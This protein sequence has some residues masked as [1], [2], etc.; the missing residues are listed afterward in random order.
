MNTYNLG[1]TATFINGRAFKPNEWG[2]EGFPII[3]IQN[4]NDDQKI[5]N[6]YNGSCDPKYRVKNGDI[7]ISWSGS[8]GVYEWKGNDAYLN[9]HIYK[10]VFDKKEINK[11]YFKYV[12]GNL[13]TKVESY[14]HGSTMKHI[15][16]KDFD[17]LKIVL[18]RPQYQRKTAAILDKADALRQLDKEVLEKYDQLTQSI[19]LD[20]FGDPASNNK[21]YKIGTIR[22]LV[23]DVRYGTSSKADPN[24]NCPYLRMNN[25]SYGGY[26]DLNDLKRINMNEKDKEKYLVRKGDLLFNRTNSKDLVGKTTVFD[27]DEEM[28]IAGY[29]IRVRTNGEANPYFIWGYL[30]SKH[31]KTTLKHMCKSIVGMAN[32]NAQEMQDIKILLP[33]VE[34]QNQF[35]DLVGKVEKQ[36][37]L[38]QKS[39]EKSEEL[40]QSLLQ[41]AFKG[42]LVK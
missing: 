20:M 25:I 7:L 3:R 4:L 39:L 23:Q 38:A 22:D 15:T 6:Y 9:Q 10:V 41:K 8:L 40:F 1:D 30:N 32:I 42:E 13:L 36:K 2:G 27:R 16:K 35:A 33:P 14:I 26:L 34:L 11:N 17:T 19:F 21:D 37:R 18:P 24:G 5:F 29:L 31:G 28:I 12:V